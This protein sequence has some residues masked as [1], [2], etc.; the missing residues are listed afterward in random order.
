M[1]NVN[2][3]N[4]LLLLYCLGNIHKI[5]EFKYVSLLKKNL[6]NYLSV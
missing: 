5:I 2:Y 4:L 3:A 6:E 1:K